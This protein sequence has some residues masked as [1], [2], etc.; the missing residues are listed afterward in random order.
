[1]PEIS[2]SRYVVHAGWNDVPH[3]DEKTKAELLASTPPHLRAARSEGTPSL[4]SGAIYPI[5]WEEV[6]CHPFAIPEYWPRAYAMDVGWNRTAAIWGAQD[7]VDKVL[8]LYSEH[9]QG[10]QLPLLHAEAIK[11]RGAWVKGAIDPASRGRSQEDGKKLINSYRQAGL[12]LTPAVNAVEAGLYEVWSLLSTGRMKIFTTLR[13]THDEYL[14]YQRDEKG[15]VVKKNDHLMDCKRYLVATW[16][17]VASVRP[18]ERSVG[19][20]PPSGPADRTGGY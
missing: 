16:K 13:N 14:I 6:T 2:P 1:M 5:P 20:S 18:M 15:K 11:A 4:G 7:P 19:E 17:A 10:Q 3:L 9:Y 12:K 8:Y